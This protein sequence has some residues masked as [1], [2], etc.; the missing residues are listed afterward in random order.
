MQAGV[1][2]DLHD[3]CLQSLCYH[4]SA[5]LF[6]ALKGCDECVGC[7]GGCDICG[8]AACD[9]AFLNRC[10]GG[11]ESV[12]DAQ[13]LFLHL[14]LGCGADLDDSNAAGELCKAL[15]E[16]FLVVLGG[17]GLDL[18]AYLADAGLDILGCTCAVD[19]DGVLLGDLDLASL[20]EHCDVGILELHAEVCGN[21]LTTGEDGDILKHLLASVAEAGSLYA[22]TS[23]GAAEFIKS[24]SR[25]SFAL[26]ILCDDEKLSA[27]LDDLLEQG[28]DLLDVGDLL[29]GDED[30]SVVQNGLHLLGIGC[31]VRRQVATVELHALD[32]LAVGLGGLGLL[33]GDN[34][35]LRHLL[36]SL[37]DKRADDLV[38][39][40]DSAYTGDITR[41]GNGLGVFTNCAD[42]G[43]GD[44]T[45]HGHGICA[46]CEVFKTLV[47]HCL[48]KHGSAGGAV[49]C[50]II[51]L[52]GDFLDKLSAHVLERV[53]KLDL[54]C[55]GNAV[56]GDQ[57]CAELLVEHN[58][59]A[60]G[61]E[62]D[63]NGI[64]KLIYAA[65]NCLAGVFAENNLFCHDSIAPF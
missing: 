40:G 59:A 9:D 14:G 50:D 23:E 38:A 57:R 8:A 49:A 7:L 35:V 53:L 3:G 1:C 62:G 4:G 37:G 19:D 22:N 47:Y 32:D 45:L 5:G 28:Q 21:D 44:A 65:L 55:D 15:L 51:R 25:K 30:E 63:L 33:D 31:H 20:A 46:R 16:L 29:I 11:V 64:C 43:L 61:A 24:N 26:D 52:G 36:H 18:S 6:V 13:L 48:C 39:G 58:I 60:L 12:L 54:L 10:T 41:A 56:I 17:G 34:A 27:G 2:G 42:G